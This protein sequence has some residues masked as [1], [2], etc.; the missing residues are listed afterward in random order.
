VLQTVRECATLESLAVGAMDVRDVETLRM[1][2]CDERACELYRVIGRIIEQL[3][4]QKL[5]RIVELG[6]RSEEAGKYVSLIVDG[7]LDDDAGKL[8]SRER[9]RVIKPPRAAATIE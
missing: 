8:I 1:V 6:R 9:R 3:N 5:R 4:G 2:A 7:Q